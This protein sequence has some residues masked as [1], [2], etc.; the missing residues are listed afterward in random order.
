MHEDFYFFLKKKVALY[1]KVN[2]YMV[3]PEVRSFF[4]RNWKNTEL[5]IMY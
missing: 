1:G 2:F 3:K 5:V 4:L